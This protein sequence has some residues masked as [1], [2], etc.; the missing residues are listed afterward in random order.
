MRSQ[1]G[2]TSSPSPSPNELWDAAGH[3]AYV[4]ALVVTGG[5]EAA[6]EAVRGALQVCCDRDAGS[7]VAT[8]NDNTRRAGV[9]GLMA[10][11]WDRRSCGRAVCSPAMAACV[12]SG[13]LGFTY[14]ETA[15]I[16]GTDDESAANLIT[17]GLIALASR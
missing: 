1:P 14:R 6:T 7:G 13:R 2:S 11:V 17:D 16:I 15:K 9:I 10:G 5:S 12:P 4:F 8:S 3:E